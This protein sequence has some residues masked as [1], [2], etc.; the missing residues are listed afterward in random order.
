MEKSYESFLFG[1]LYTLCICFLYN[2][3][4]LLKK[5]HLSFLQVNFQARYEL[6][7]K[8]PTNISIVQHWP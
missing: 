8:G 3:F 2:C 1:S 4:Y 6:K 7:I 5:K